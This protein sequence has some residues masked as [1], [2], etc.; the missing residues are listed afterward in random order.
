VAGLKSDPELEALTALCR[1]LA[2]RGLG[3]G[4]RDARPAL[5]VQVKGQSPLRITVDSLG[6]FFLWDGP[7]RPYPVADPAGAADVIA[8][9]VNA[10]RSGDGP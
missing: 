1:Q 9:Q 7:G 5:V 3:V 2:L 6:S 4:M 10:R 8:K